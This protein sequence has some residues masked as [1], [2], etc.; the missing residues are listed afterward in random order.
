[1]SDFLGFS[2]NRKKYIGDSCKD[3]YRHI[4]AL[5]DDSEL[6][7]WFDYFE[8]AYSLPKDIVKIQ[9]IRFLEVNY[10]YQAACFHPA[11]RSI[12]SFVSFFKNI[13]VLCYALIHSKKRKKRGREFL[14]LIDGV[15]AK[16][17]EGAKEEVVYFQSLIDLYGK[18]NVLI[19]SHNNISIEG[20]AVAYRPYHRFYH[21]ELIWAVLFKEFFMGFW[22]CAKFSWKK[23]VNFFHLS[24]EITNNYLYYSSLFN[25]YKFRDVIQLR[26]YQTNP[27]KDHLLHVSGGRYS[28]T[29]QKN[30]YQIGRNGF[31]YHADVFFSLGK[32]TVEN[33]Y[34]YGARIGKVLPVGSFLMEHFW[35][36]REHQE[37][38]ESFDVLFL[39]I[40]MVKA[41]HFMD[42]YEDFEADY[43]D[44]IRWLVRFSNENPQY[45]IGIKHHE[46]NLE[47]SHE[48][49]IIAESRVKQID[50]KANS[51]QLA[52]SAKCVLT[53]GSTMGYEMAA[54]G[55]PV[56]FLDPGGRCALLP[57]LEEDF[58]RKNRAINY[59]EFLEKLNIFLLRQSNDLLNGVASDDLCLKSDRV[60]KR[61]YE[62]LNNGEGKVE[63]KN[64]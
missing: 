36:S 43:Y 26:H 6:D 14:L 61:I 49:Q 27:I 29:I 54:H 5:V 24:R 11:L 60:S 39:G 55:V 20:L 58:F 9:T 42:A 45:R 31:C 57:Q 13:G 25:D 12:E 16:K 47:N 41:M 28:A 18:E 1:M 33:A 46:N 4:K 56:L 44:S 51:Y 37:A 32:K 40:N 64:Y 53:F 38:L 17:D 3:L 19:V 50:K 23:K 2:H 62:Y 21:R 48:E 35:F 15:A 8:K 63:T 30:I 52:F 34:D 10:Q 59:E 22:L 7:T